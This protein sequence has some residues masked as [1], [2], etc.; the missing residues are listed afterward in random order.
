MGEFV[1]MGPS[2]EDEGK[3]GAAAGS[4]EDTPMPSELEIAS[5]GDAVDG[6]KPLP[7]TPTPAPPKHK[8]RPGFSTPTFSDLSTLT[9]PHPR[10]YF[11]PK[12][13]SWALCAPSKPVA[14]NTST[15]GAAAA[16][17]SFDPK[18]FTSNSIPPEEAEA[19]LSEHLSPPLSRP[20]APADSDSFSTDYGTY[21]PWTT[22]RAGGLIELVGNKGTRAVLSPTG[23]YP[24]VIGR[25]LWERLLKKRGEDPPP[26]TVLDNLLFVGETRSLPVDGKGFQKAMPMDDPTYVL[27]VFLLYCH[28]L[29]YL[30]YPSHDLLL[31]TLG[32][33]AQGVA[34][35][36]WF[37]QS[38]TSALRKVGPNAQGCVLGLT[39]DVAD[40]VVDKVYDLQWLGAE[41]KGPFF[42]EALT[43]TAQHRSSDTLQT[44]LVMEAS[45]DRYPCSKIN[46]AYSELRL[47]PPFDTFS[48]IPTEDELLTAFEIRNSA[49]EHPARRKI[50][51]EAAKVVAKWRGSETHAAIIESLPAEKG[52]G[53]G[54]EGREGMTDV[55][56]VTAKMDLPRACV[57]LDV[58]Q[59]TDDQML[60]MVHPIRL[61]DATTHSKKEKVRE[62]LEVI[63]EA[64]IFDCSTWSS[65]TL[66]A[67][68]SLST[69]LSQLL[70]HRLPVPDSAR[71]TC[72]RRLDAG[73]LALALR[74]RTAAI[75]I[76]PY[77]LI[78]T[79]RLA[80]L[81]WAEQ[82]TV[83]VGA[84]RR[85]TRQAPPPSPPPPP[86]VPL[87][88]ARTQPN[89]SSKDE[90][91]MST[92]PAVDIAR[93]V[94]NKL[95]QPPRVLSNMAI[96][97]AAVV[98]PLTMENGFE[99]Q[100]ESGRIREWLAVGD[101]AKEQCSSF[102]N[103]ASAAR[104]GVEGP[105]WVSR[106]EDGVKLLSSIA[107]EEVGYPVQKRLNSVSIAY[108]S[109]VQV[110]TLAEGHVN[111]DNFWT[112]CWVEVVYRTSNSYF[113]TVYNSRL[114]EPWSLSKAIS[115]AGSAA[116]LTGRRR[117]PQHFFNSTTTFVTV[118]ISDTSVATPAAVSDSS[119]PESNLT[120]L[121]TS[122]SASS[123]S[124]S[125]LTPSPTL[126][127]R[128]IRFQRSPT[129][130]YSAHDSF[131]TAQRSIR[132]SLRLTQLPPA[133]PSMATSQPHLPGSNPANA[134]ASNNRFAPIATQSE[135]NSIQST[136]EA[137][138]VVKGK[139]GIETGQPV[140][141]AVEAEVEV[142]RR[143]L[144]D[145]ESRRNILRRYLNGRFGENDVLEEEEVV[146]EPE[147]LASVSVRV[148]V[149]PPQ[150]WKDDQAADA[151]LTAYRSAR[152]GSLMARDFGAKVETL[153][154][155][156]FDRTID[157]ADRVSSFVAGLN[158]NYREFL[159]TQL[160]TLKTMGRA[161][162]TLS[163]HVDLAAAADGLDS[164]TSSLKKTG[165]VSS[166]PSSS[167]SPS[168]KV[169]S[170]AQNPSPAGAGSEKTAR[171]RTRAEEW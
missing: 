124:L 37:L 71:I 162:V 16:P 153:A 6:E 119:S 116:S 78:S 13:F 29:D 48:S 59:G 24:C 22:A 30:S 74:L 132:R 83:S 73:A 165:G 154:D 49:V 171:W 113:F 122:D 55:T 134:W 51:L 158:A 79:E 148:K 64:R 87:P 167:S 46:Q 144:A 88:E 96:C 92:L 170:G 15:Y 168:K 2:I 141:S 112:D 137:S 145:L 63:E 152:Q 17:S 70:S 5:E 160:A 85:R 1:D 56:V 98:P 69:L 115:L 28:E 100:M 89:R 106:D 25:D 38:Q 42:L 127:R 140:E 41:G 143:E 94:D 125:D 136:D 23:W 146:M 72:S 81:Q 60:L 76:G 161:P 57:V 62:A 123:S 44:K 147:E 58:E 32:F 105:L 117:W 130:S 120:P 142:V 40:E 33:T 45:R 109:G 93:S 53:S 10:L 86:S 101:E 50:L 133:P 68:P 20:C 169:G 166:S 7:A 61:N 157:E 27:L 14:A 102:Q 8:P 118:T 26:G 36:S 138:A 67:P 80:S 151:A 3:V 155:A 31:A 77:R 164:F 65:P 111:R 131:V 104:A 95:D 39:P 121:S 108:Q 91:T 52:D 150:A 21:T 99:L 128:S 47:P 163:A 110:H 107:R 90:Y 126:P 18:L 82:E 84:P 35:A 4:G 75:S 139:G 9:R 11:C 43:R 97:R 159:K 149:N 54:V 19:F 12:T 129:H 156:C 103:A 66:S 34:R 114:L 135:A